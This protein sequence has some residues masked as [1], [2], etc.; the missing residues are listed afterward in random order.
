MLSSADN[1]QQV[2]RVG[3]RQIF[4]RG[5]REIDLRAAGCRGVVLNRHGLA[6]GQRRHVEDDGIS[7]S[8]H[9]YRFEPGERDHAAIQ[10]DRASTGWTGNRVLRRVSNCVGRAADHVQRIV[11]CPRFAAFES[12]AA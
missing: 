12:Q 7:R 5:G 9:Q 6:A 1:P 4:Q 10:I 3:E 11:V 2:R 8:A